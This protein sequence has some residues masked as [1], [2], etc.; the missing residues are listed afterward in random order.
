MSLCPRHERN[1]T[2]DRYH[3]AIVPPVIQR[4]ILENPAWYTAYTPY[5]PE[6]S[7][8][9][10]ESL[11]NFQ[12]VVISLTALP[13]ANASLLDES[14]ACAEGMAMCLA[15]IPKPKFNKGKK[16]FLVSPSVAP[17][18]LAVLQTRASGF[19]IELKVAKSNDGLEKEIEELGEEKLMGALVQYPDV[20]G[21]IKDW[22]S[23]AGKVK[24]A[25]AK[26]VVA[27]D[28]LAL[29]MLKPPG[30][31]GADIVCGNTQRFGKSR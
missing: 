10:L 9:R 17:Q 19:G 24:G 28:L 22:E 29:T 30:E 6:Q 5:S 21:D 4:N 18:T 16:V 23:V 11:I 1:S 25:G 7:Q 14:T 13:I 31:W 20:D 15:S 12:T 27:S 8:G 2:N 3:N 26:L